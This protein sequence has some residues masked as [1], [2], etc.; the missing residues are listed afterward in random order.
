VSGTEQPITD[1]IKL[2]TLTQRREMELLIFTP[3]PFAVWG[4]TLAKK[5]GFP[6][7]LGGIAGFFLL[8]VGIITLYLIKKDSPSEDLIESN[9]KTVSS[10]N[11][12]KASWLTLA[13]GF[14]IAFGPILLAVADAAVND[15]FGNFWYEYAALGFLLIVTLPAGFIAGVIGIVMLANPRKSKK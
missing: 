8:I 3:A 13:S 10:N 11:F 6:P 15:R 5:R 1:G 12:R 4:W 9:G 7:I 2:Q 14:L